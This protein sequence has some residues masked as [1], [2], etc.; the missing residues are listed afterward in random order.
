MVSYFSVCQTMFSN[1]FNNNSCSFV[2]R[3]LPSRYC[4]K[5]FN[6]VWWKT[7]VLIDE[8]S[9]KKCQ[10]NRSWSFVSPS[11][12]RYMCERWQCNFIR[13]YTD[14][15]GDVKV[16][17]WK[18]L[19]ANRVPLMT[20]SVDQLKSSKSSTFSFMSPSHFLQIVCSLALSS[21]PTFSLLLPITRVISLL[22][23]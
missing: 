5:P 15:S 13:F 23:L 16:T 11:S 2:E 1:L 12:K 8:L 17:L 9:H 7:T 21:L 10:I 4:V 3:E 14:W 20:R 19:L 18:I 22:S 6:S